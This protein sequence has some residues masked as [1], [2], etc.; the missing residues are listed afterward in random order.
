MELLPLLLPAIVLVILIGCLAVL[1]ERSLN[2]QRKGSLKRD[3]DERN[4]AGRL[5]ERFSNW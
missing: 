2:R 4:A 1:G 3:R 5:W